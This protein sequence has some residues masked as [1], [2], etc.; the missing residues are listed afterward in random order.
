MKDEKDLGGTS[1][2]A[3]DGVSVS[4]SDQLSH[5]E[6]VYVSMDDVRRVF[7]EMRNGPFVPTL[8]AAEFLLTDYAEP[9]AALIAKVGAK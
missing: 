9:L 5:A 4:V 2:T 3:V 1:L 6:P 7:D 8:G